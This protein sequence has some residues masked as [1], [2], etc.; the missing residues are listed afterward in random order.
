MKN[1][2]SD[3]V[4]SAALDLI[5]KNGK[6]T[7]LEVKNHLRVQ[8]FWAKQQDVSRMMA[9][10]AEA[11]GWESV[12]NGVY[13]VYSIS[14]STPASVQTSSIIGGQK[15]QRIASII[16]DVFSVPLS[17]IK[18]LSKLSLLTSSDDVEDAIAQLE[19]ELEGAGFVGVRV[20]QD[21]TVLDVLTAVEE[22]QSA[23]QTTAPAAATPLAQ[24]CSTVNIKPLA[25]IMSGAGQNIDD[26]LLKF[27]EKT[28][29]VSSPVN[30]DI[31]LIDSSHSRDH[32]RC[33][34]ARMFKMPIQSTRACRL[35]HF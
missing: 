28:W 32:A 25:N 19:D 8:S 6:T 12:S 16:A 3:I 14:Q 31:L 2:T 7:T 27:G 15:T 4:L 22:A 23:S 5:Q 17:D 10:L 1:L 30:N 33:V 24:R 26:L 18:P 9:D 13:N 11:H 21:D 34:Y 35:N 29:V 20:S